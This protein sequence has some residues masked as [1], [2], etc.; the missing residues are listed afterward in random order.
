MIAAYS[1]IN[2][3]CYREIRGALSY[4]SVV[5]RPHGWT[6]PQQTAKYQQHSKKKTVRG[7]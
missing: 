5:I 3:Q 6:T 4:S 7:Y 2:V 1:V